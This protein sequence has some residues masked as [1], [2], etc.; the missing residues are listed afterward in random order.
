MPVP[1]VSVYDSSNAK[2]RGPDALPPQSAG[3]L[4]TAPNAGGVMLSTAAPARKPFSCCAATFDGE[5]DPA[6]GCTT[7]TSRAT[8]TE[9]TKSLP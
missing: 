6:T 9:A 5:A 2:R 8:E 3:S 1:A 7:P 4:P